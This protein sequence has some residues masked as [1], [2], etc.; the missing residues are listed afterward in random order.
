MKYEIDRNWKGPSG[1]S[2]GSTCGMDYIKKVSDFETVVSVG[3]GYSG[4]KIHRARAFLK[5]LDNGLFG[6]VD[7]WIC[8]GS[9]SW[10]SNLR[11]NMELSDVADLRP[12]CKRCCPD[13]KPSVQEIR[14]T[15][16]SQR[17]AIANYENIMP[18]ELKHSLK[19]NGSNLVS[20]GN[21]MYKLVT[22]S[23]SLGWKVESTFVF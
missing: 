3:V 16:L 7:L 12:T 22:C 1:E 14:E 10:K 4:T 15:R 13:K 9:Q 21:T 23:G 11:F 2:V 5:R 18:I 19:F 20:W 17:I 6:L 8:C